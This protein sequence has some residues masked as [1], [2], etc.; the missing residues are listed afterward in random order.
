MTSEQ[1]MNM[2]VENYIGGRVVKTTPN[3]IVKSPFYDY[4]VI[5][6]NSASREIEMALGYTNTYSRLHPI[7]PVSVLE[8]VKESGDLF[9]IEPNE[10]LYAVKMTGLPRKIVQAN[11][12]TMKRYMQIFGEI[13]RQRYDVN[14]NELY[15]D[16][17]NGSRELR[18]P[19]ESTVVAYMPLGDL[20]PPIFVI[21]HSLISQRGIVVRPSS[22]LAYFSVK[23]AQTTT[24]TARRKGVDLDGAVNVLMWDSTDPSRKVNTEL[25]NQKIASESRIGF[26]NTTTLEMLGV[27]IAYDRGSCKAIVDSGV[28]IDMAAK[29]V[30]DGALENPLACDTTRAVWVHQSIAR[31]FEE[32]LTREFARRKVGDPLDDD[33]DIGFVGFNDLTQTLNLI[34]YNT[35]W[36]SEELLYPEVGHA[37]QIRVG[38]YQAPPMI[39][40]AHNLESPLMRGDHNVYMLLVRHF[41]DLHTAIREITSPLLPHP[42]SVSYYGRN[43]KGVLD[44]A[45]QLPALHLNIGKNTRM[46]DLSLPHQG[47]YPFETWTAPVS[48]SS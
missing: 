16:L 35:R 39:L 34:G 37:S 43:I 21:S 20:F 32:A 17:G 18:V 2:I 9:S 44:L 30:A 5:L 1:T 36:G 25:I 15:R 11:L 46:H 29:S 40:R 38:D 4:S 28:D 13:V 22:S 45:R 42:L 14:E 27:G 23:L 6:P 3:F 7:G 26:G 8:I 19:T 24:E 31:E 47:K 12:Q 10:I 33:T 48:I 41:S